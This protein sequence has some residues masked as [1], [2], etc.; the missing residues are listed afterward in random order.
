MVYQDGGMSIGAL[1]VVSPTAS[2]QVFSNALVGPL[3]IHR[4]MLKTSAC[5]CFIVFSLEEGNC[6]LAL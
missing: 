2:V 4:K 3:A 1:L 5:H 6:N